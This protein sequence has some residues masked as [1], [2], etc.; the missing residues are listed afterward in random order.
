MFQAPACGARLPS[1]RTTGWKRGCIKAYY[2]LYACSHSLESLSPRTRGECA[3]LDGSQDA[4]F[5]QKFSPAQRSGHLDLSEC[6]LCAGPLTRVT[7]SS[8]SLSRPWN[9]CICFWWSEE[10]FDLLAISTFVVHFSGVTLKLDF[11]YMAVW[12]RSG[13][14]G[15]GNYGHTLVVDI[16]LSLNDTIRDI[17]NSLSL[18]FSC[19]PVLGFFLPSFLSP[20]RV[21]CVVYSMYQSRYKRRR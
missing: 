19:S 8:I 11:Q 17:P 7:D 13:M 10:C 18:V 16:L 9:V 6:Q 15:S 3:V 2:Q 4:I 21:S 20:L 12:T 5:W 1:C 14:G